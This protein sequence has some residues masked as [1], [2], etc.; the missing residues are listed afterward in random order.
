[1]S[2]TEL[3]TWLISQ[4]NRRAHALLSDRLSAAGSS[5]YEYRVLDALSASPPLSQVAIGSFSRM[6]RRDV[7]VTLA[8]LADRGL[9]SKESDP[10]DARRNLVS[11]TPAGKERFEGLTTI[12]NEVQEDLLA[13]FDAEARIAVLEALRVLGS[14]GLLDER[15]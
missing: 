1:M 5:G 7:A 6:D 13:P 10:D 4:A 11:L 9:V 15:A 3:P 2:F 12:V 14:V 8:S